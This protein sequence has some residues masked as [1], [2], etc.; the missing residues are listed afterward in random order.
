MSNLKFKHDVNDFATAERLC[1]EKAGDVT[2]CYNTVL[3]KVGEGYAVVHHWTP[4]VTFHPDGSAT[5]SGS[6]VSATTANRLQH[7][8]PEMVERINR[9]HGTYVVRLKDHPGYFVI[10]EGERAR[11][12]PDHTVVMV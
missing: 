6:W 2:L 3:A 1:M 12:Y 9:D 8:K 7:Y 10:E 5:L 4:I 11:V